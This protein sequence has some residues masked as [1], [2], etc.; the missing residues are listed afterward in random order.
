MEAILSNA[1]VAYV[2]LV[3]GFV[4]AL[5]AVVTPGTG[6][7]EIGALFCLA[8]AAYQVYV[9]GF[10]LWALVV[11]IL[12]VFPFVYAIRKPK[13]EWALALSILG[14]IVGSLFLF[15]T[16]GWR[17]SVNPI[18]A[19]ITS[20]VTAS[21][22]WFIVHKALAAFQ[23]RPS[24]DLAMLIGQIGEAKTEVHAEGSVQVAG[25]LWTA[26]SEKAIPAGE[27]VRVIGREGFVLIV[28]KS[29]QS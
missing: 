6:M 25:E 12:A 17:I 18:V 26:R 19:I 1:N 23:T 9:I 14:I 5:L 3:L 27:P 7:L 22:L 8:V 21:L 13:R 10:N 4:L 15:T 29:D 20:L 16:E 24:H 11:L 28:E 2:V